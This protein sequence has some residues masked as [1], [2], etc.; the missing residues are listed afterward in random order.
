MPCWKCLGLAFQA[1]V[2]CNKQKNILD[3]SI[4]HALPFLLLTNAHGE[5]RGEFIIMI[6]QIPKILPLLRRL[7][8][9]LFSNVALTPF[10]ARC[11]WTILNS[12]VWKISQPNSHSNWE[13]TNP[14]RYQFFISLS[15]AQSPHPRTAT[16]KRVRRCGDE[17]NEMKNPPTTS[18]LLRFSMVFNRPNL[19][20][21]S[22]DCES[23]VLLS[24]FKFRCLSLKII[25]L[26]QIDLF[27]KSNLTIADKSVACQ[28]FPSFSDRSFSKQ[29]F[30][31]LQTSP[32]C[33]PISFFLPPE[34]RLYWLYWFLLVSLCFF[35]VT[36]Y[37]IHEI[38]MVRVYYFSRLIALQL[39]Q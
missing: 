10:S 38:P 1:H 19:E 35:K 8:S 33:R 37:E 11:W 17:K 28:H 30:L 39:L 13:E 16:E 29:V 12:H 3:L 15:S 22:I 18:L 36:R 20:N 27:R 7:F 32:N 34:W 24:D 31:L 14:K 2:L 6:A 25:I 23:I 21:Q 9:R 26:S 4:A 5:R